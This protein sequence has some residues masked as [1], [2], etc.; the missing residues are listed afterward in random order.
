MCQVQIH[1]YYYKYTFIFPNHSRNTRVHNHQSSSSVTKPSWCG[2]HPQKHPL[3]N[4]FAA[5]TCANFSSNFN[6]SEIK[7]KLQQWCTEK[8]SNY[9]CEQYEWDYYLETWHLAINFDVKWVW[10]YYTTVRANVRWIT[11]YTYRNQ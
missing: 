11:K 10:E 4:V 9:E 8:K 3:S 2:F 6:V 7:K 5:D 1:F